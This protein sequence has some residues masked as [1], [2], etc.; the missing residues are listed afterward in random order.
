MA[1][2]ILQWVVHAART[3]TLTELAEARAIILGQPV[4]SDRRRPIS[5]VSFQKL[6]ESSCAPLVEVR[7][8]GVLQL[9]HH[10]TK[11]YLLQRPQEIQSLC[12]SSRSQSKEI[13]VELV[14]PHHGLANLC[15]GYL[16]LEKFP[17]HYSFPPPCFARPHDSPP[18]QCRFARQQHPR[19]LLLVKINT[20]NRVKF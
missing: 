9:I 8:D 7:P 20:A 11:E 15:L 10:T 3:L 6:I 2:F 1:G 13:G 5:L 19:R 4:L 12:N 14:K 16:N 18:Q 17:S